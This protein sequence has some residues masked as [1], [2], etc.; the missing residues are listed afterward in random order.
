MSKYPAR[1]HA[2][3]LA[4]ALLPLLPEEQRT[5]THVVILQACPTTCRDDT[6]RE[7]SFHQEANFN[8]LTG[9]LVP[10][11]TVVI[12]IKYTNTNTKIESDSVAEISHKLYIPPADPLV[13]LWSVAPPTLEEAIATYE[14]DSISYTTDLVAPI[15]SASGQVI[16][17]TLPITIEF[18][19]LPSILGLGLEKGFQGHTTEYLRNA[20]H[21]ARLIKTDEEIQL[22]R[23]AN[24]I[25]SG[26][27]EVLMR[28][29]GRFAAS[30]N[31]NGLAVKDGKKG[32]EKGQRTGKEA[33]KE[34]EVE[35][36]MDAEALFVAVCKRSGAEQ[37]YLPIVASGTRA[38][39]L[40][41]VCNDRLFPSTATPRHPGDTTFI[42]KPL[43]KGCCGSVPDHDH[44]TPAT[45]FHSSAFQPQ[46]LLMDAG[47][48]WRGYA[49]DITRTIPIGNGG[50]FT[51]RAAEIYDT[52]LRMQKESEAMIRPGIHWDTLHLHTHKVLID[53]FLELGIFTGGTAEEILASGISAAFYPHGLGHAL[54]LDVHDSLQY[55]RSTH[56]DIPPESKSS[57]LYTYLRIRQP[58]QKGF[59]LTVEPGCYFAP[60]MMEEHGVWENKYVNKDKL[61][62]YIPV[63]GVR[64]EDVVVVTKDGWEN[65][66]TVGRERKWVEAVCSGEDQVV[67]NGH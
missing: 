62:D 46:V 23:E 18:P 31:G 40:H 56:I 12:S 27:H 55:L 25:S 9:C 54:G 10:S 33:L 36:E 59:V 29:L 21:I 13:T 4:A 34:W 38:S 26:A 15:S 17:H 51:D 1:Q 65:L 53:R 58:L 44:A 67:S 49:S 64:I 43:A 32:G 47:C 11:A 42:P 14:S 22:I 45:S 20:L 16:I 37:A 61:R 24:R 52:V 19:P 41:Y 6:D 30:R 5:K 48:E 3:K 35:S 63:G 60:Q 7:M 39:T 8:Y 57:K 66:T 50:K 28:E 2:T